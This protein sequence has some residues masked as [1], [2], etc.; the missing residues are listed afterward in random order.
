MHMQQDQFLREQYIPLLE[1]INP[2]QAPLWGKM[3]YHHMLEHMMVSFQVSSQHE[4]VACIHEPERVAK[5]Q[6]FLLTDIP[7]KENTKSPLLGE[8]LEPLIYTSIEL[9]LQGLKKAMSTYFNQYTL[10]EDVLVFHPIFGTLDKKLN[11]AL[12]YK[13]AVHH[14]KQFGV[15]L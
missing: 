11:D 13:H 14:L 7:F 6:A 3:S 10:Q 12:L 9:A 15:E 1:Q 2:N 4:P 8:A 5:M